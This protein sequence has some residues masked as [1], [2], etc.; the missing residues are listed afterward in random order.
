MFI[1]V[2]IFSLLAIV[3]AVLSHLY[4][5]GY[6]PLT[7]YNRWWA[8]GIWWRFVSIGLVFN[9]VANL[10]LTRRGKSCA[11]PIPAET[12]ASVEAAC[13]PPSASNPAPPADTGCTLA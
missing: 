10:L 1:A 5:W 6:L 7:I 13:V 3:S 4:V 12:P 11:P 2:W 9:A 8:D